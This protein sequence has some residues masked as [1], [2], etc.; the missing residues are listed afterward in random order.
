[1]SIRYRCTILDDKGKT[2]V[3]FTGDVTDTGKIKFAI[4]DDV[5]PGGT[6]EIE[7]ESA[8]PNSGNSQHQ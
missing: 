4:P 1:M 7:W 5:Q 8:K 2:D 3:I 6:L